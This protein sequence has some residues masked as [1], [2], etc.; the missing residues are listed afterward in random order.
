MSS[1]G[2]RIGSLKQV[3]ELRA[4]IAELERENDALHAELDGTRA[5]LAQAREERDKA[6]LYCAEVAS[7]I[8]DPMYDKV[9][10][11]AGIA[12][13]AEAMATGEMTGRYLDI[14][15][16][17]ERAIRAEDALAAERERRGSSSPE[18]IARRFHDAYERLAPQFGYSTRPESRREWDEL[19][20]N[21]RD[22]MIAVVRNVLI[23]QPA[24]DAD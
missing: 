23:E 19:P 9:E 18:D 11:R 10:N 2:T 4:R 8:C 12:A 6:R 16:Q 22:L 17:T 1:D 15:M 20:Q 3:V 5:E 21:L 24:A 14:K 7:Y 13:D